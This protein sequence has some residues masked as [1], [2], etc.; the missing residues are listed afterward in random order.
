MPEGPEIYVQTKKLAK[1]IK[2]ENIEDIKFLSNKIIKNYDEIQKLLPLKILKVYSK[3]KKTIIE[4]EKS[5]YLVFS[6]TKHHT[7]YI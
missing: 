2:N 3:G 7:Q 1:K 6:F 5:W 4:L